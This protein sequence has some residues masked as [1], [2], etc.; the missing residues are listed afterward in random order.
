MKYL[1]S[2]WLLTAAIA[3]G[4]GFP[5]AKPSALVAL[6]PGTAVAVRINDKLSS[7]KND[8]GDRFTGVLETALTVNHVTVA[9]KRSEVIGR[10]ASRRRGMQGDELSLELV[11]ITALDGTSVDIV[12]EPLVRQNEKSVTSGVVQVGSLAGLGA[13]IG[14]LA[15]SGRGA[16]IG[17]ATGGAAGVAGPGKAVEI[18]RESVLVF[19]LREPVKAIRGQ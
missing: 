2:I 11:S 5:E 16:A 6:P 4:D 17:A 7:K 15:G 12:T 1:S 14:A 3:F 13:A 8:S 18:K 9:E 10:I 19:R